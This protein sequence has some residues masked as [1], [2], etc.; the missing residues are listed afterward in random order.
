[1]LTIRELAEDLATY[2]EVT[3]IEL[4]DLEP[5]MIVNRFIDRVEERQQYLRKALYDADAGRDGV[6]DLKKARHYLDR[7]IEKYDENSSADTL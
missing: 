3:V 2:D 1:M 7:M 6:E 5:D 4:L